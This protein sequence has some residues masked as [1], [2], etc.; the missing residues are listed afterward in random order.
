MNSPTILG[1]GGNKIR[2]K[3]FFI[4]FSLVSKATR[5]ALIHGSQEWDKVEISYYTENDLEEFVVWMQSVD[6]GH[7][8]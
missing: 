7:G 5:N 8:Y 6:V 2:D 4:A 3:V 1:I